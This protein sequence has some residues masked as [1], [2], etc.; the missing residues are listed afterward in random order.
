MVQ[1]HL[2]AVSPLRGVCDDAVA[3]S[4]SQ[5]AHAVYAAPSGTPSP[6]QY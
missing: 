5:W 2:I 3:S 1:Q 6:S 4:L